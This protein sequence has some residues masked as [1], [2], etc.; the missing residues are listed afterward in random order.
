MKRLFAFLALVG[1]TNVAVAAEIT[2]NAK[3]ADNK[4]AMCIGCHGIP[5]YKA[6]F[7][8]V[9]QVPMIGGQSAKYIESALNAYKKG[10]R[11]NPSMRGIAA[12]LSD[13]DIADL[14]A[15]YSQQK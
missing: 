11:K 4:I 10:D 3:A 14:A 15:Y 12:G 8:E 7:P 5:G 1:I 6:T 9:Y 13:Q 2:G